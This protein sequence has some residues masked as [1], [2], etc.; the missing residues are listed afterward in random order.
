V[1]GLVFC[2]GVCTFISGN[3]RM[4]LKFVKEDVGLRVLDGIRKNLRMSP[5]TWWRCFSGY[6]SCWEER[7]KKTT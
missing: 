1:V 7:K 5:W 2:M 4:R 3:A 6:N